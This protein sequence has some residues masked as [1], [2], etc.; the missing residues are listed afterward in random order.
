MHSIRIRRF[1]AVDD[2]GPTFEAWLGD[3]LLFSV[4]R[5]EGQELQ[6]LFEEGIVGRRVPLEGLVAAL[7]EARKRL[8]EEPA[9]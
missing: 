2:A 8:A 1:H 3:E 6:V 5:S 7:E 4:F 9:D